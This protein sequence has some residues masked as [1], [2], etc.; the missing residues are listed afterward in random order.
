MRAGA[1]VL[2]L[3]LAAATGCAPA[4][5]PA[6]RSSATNIPPAKEVGEPIACDIE[7]KHLAMPRD[8]LRETA[9]ERRFELD[10][11]RSKRSMQV[12]VG[13][14][15]QISLSW[16]GKAQPHSA[17]NYLEGGRYALDGASL[18][19]HRIAGDAAA[20]DE[21]SKS[22]RGLVAPWMAK[23][24][25]LPA[26][27][28]PGVELDARIAVLI[29]EHFWAVPGI[30][31]VSVERPKATVVAPVERDSARFLRV[32]ISLSAVLPSER[33]HSLSGEV[34][35]RIPDGALVELSMEADGRPMRREGPRFI[36]MQ[37]FVKTVCEHGDAIKS[38]GRPL[39]FR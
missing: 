24:S 16:E 8:G 5:V 33:K 32:K 19:V 28:Q 30:E 39:L 17:V 12:A 25:P 21:E 2:L 15:E 38:R 1:V 35:L 6:A 14:A 22:L 9:L 3:W 10:L 4:A 7:L 34:L 36:N 23:P 27:I 13:A 26:D 37:Y 11:L 20:Y 29:A 18:K 31:L